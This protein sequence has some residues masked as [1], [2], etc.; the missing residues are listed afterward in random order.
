[1]ADRAA[2]LQT[3]LAGLLAEHEPTL[4]EHER[5][6]LL[7][8]E[9]RC[10]WRPG[11]RPTRPEPMVVAFLNLFDRAEQEELTDRTLSAG[12]VDEL[13][14]TFREQLARDAV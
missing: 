4:R 9:R 8:L 1:M 5:A 7:Q 10:A 13:R 11:S 6:D 2:D 12:T 3:E 14:R